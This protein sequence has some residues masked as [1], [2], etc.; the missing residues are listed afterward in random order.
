MADRRDIDEVLRS[1][2]VCRMAMCDGDDPYVL[3]LSYGYDGASLFIHCA[4]EGRKLDVLRRNSKV[5]F[6]VDGD[7]A[8]V[9]ADQVCRRPM[10]YRCVVG[11]GVATILD[12]ME[13]KIGALKVLM[14]HQ[15][16]PGDWS[17][18]P[19]VVAKTL[20]IRVEIK[21]MTGKRSGF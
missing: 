3:P 21:E 16:G 5:C 2:K 6:V 1:H 7:H 17:F 19:D 12:S 20:A 10:R 9:P 4:R 13:E 8:F 15:Y 14:D 18:D 11:T